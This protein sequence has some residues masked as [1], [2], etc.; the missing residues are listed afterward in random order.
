LQWKI[1]YDKPVIISEFGADAPAGRHGDKDERWTEEY[2]VNVFQHQIA[3][4]QRIPGFAGLSPWVLVDFRSPRRPLP[5]IQDYFNRK[6]LISNKGAYK[7]AFSTLQE[8][9]EDMEHQ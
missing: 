6:G 2:Q 3:M 9:Y 1:A 5:G 4:V 8:F 7:Q